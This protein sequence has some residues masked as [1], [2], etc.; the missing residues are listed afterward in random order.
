MWRPM[1]RGSLSQNI[2]WCTSSSWAPSTAA[3]SKTSSVEETA[4]ATRSTRSAPM[5][6][7]PIGRVVAV[8]VRLELGV[9]EGQDLVAGGA[10]AQ[11]V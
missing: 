4:E 8:A 1:A 7:I 11:R 10:H 5:T 9:E 2:P 6:C 3:R